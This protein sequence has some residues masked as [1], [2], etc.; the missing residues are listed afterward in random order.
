MVIPDIMWRALHQSSDQL[1]ALH[2]NDLSRGR[3]LFLVIE[4]DLF[5]IEM[6]DQLVIGSLQSSVE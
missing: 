5:R 6:L 1:I 4:I 2:T 3:W